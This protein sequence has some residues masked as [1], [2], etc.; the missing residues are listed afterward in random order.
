MGAVEHAQHLVPTGH[1]VAILQFQE[2]TALSGSVSRAAADERLDGRRRPLAEGLPDGRT[3]RQPPCGCRLPIWRKDLL[4]L[5]W[6]S[7]SFQI[8][9]APSPSTTTRWAQPRPRR[10]AAASRCRPKV[11]AAA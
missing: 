1:V 10:C 2:N 9:L 6:V 8:H 11:W 3:A 7:A 5:E 4:E